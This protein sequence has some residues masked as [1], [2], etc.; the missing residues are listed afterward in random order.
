MPQGPNRGNSSEE[1]LGDVDLRVHLIDEAVMPFRVE[2]LVA[3]S[4]SPG[5]QVLAALVGVQ[6]NQFC[7]A[8]DIALALRRE[9]IPVLIGGFHVSGM[10]AMFPTISPEIGKSSR[11]A[12][13]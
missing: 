13:P 5:Q 3:I 11:R 6:T 7:R 2:Q 12:S 4:H 10:M 1:I 9:G 8:A